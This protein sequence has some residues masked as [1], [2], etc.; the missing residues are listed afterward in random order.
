MDNLQVSDIET[1]LQ[2][3]SSTASQDDKNK[4][5]QF[6]EQFQ[7]ST[8][9]WS[10]CNEILSKEDPTNA[11][12]ELNIF[13][14]QTLRNKVTYDLSQ[15]ENNLPQFKDSLLTLLLS[16]NQKLIITQLN[17]AL[18]RLAIQFLEWQNPIFEIISLLNSSPSILLNFLRILPEETLDIASTPLT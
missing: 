13:A 3:I 11:L 15:L 18:A 14:A 10:I 1:A 6:L 16:H 8:V 9:A 7:R 17:V 12:L 5:L 2:C 4:A